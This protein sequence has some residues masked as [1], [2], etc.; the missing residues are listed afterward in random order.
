MGAALTRFSCG[1]ESSAKGRI[2]SMSLFGKHDLDSDDPRVRLEAVKES[3][4][5]VALT[6]VAIKDEW[7][8]VRLAAVGRVRNDMLLAR[9]AREA[10]ELDVRLSAVERIASQKLLG[11]LIREVGNRELIGVCLSRITDLEVI[12]VI[13]EDTKCSPTVRKLAIEHF[14]DEG[15]LAEIVGAVHSGGDDEEDEGRKSDSAVDA[16][17]SAHGGGIRGVRAIGRFRRSEKALR[18]LGT[19][20]RRGGETGGLAVEYLCGALGSPNAELATCAT[21]ELSGLGDADVVAALVRAL[22]NPALREPI[23]GVLGRIDTPEARSALGN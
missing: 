5:E 1:S 11:E 9:V 14:A 6:T 21:E 2:A 23:R 16:L 15:Y 18:A 13:A 17:L 20:A 7:P 8:R 4:D 10:S 3:T 22:D 12:Q 19:I